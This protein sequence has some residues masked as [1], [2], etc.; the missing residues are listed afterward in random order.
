MY[1]LLAYAGFLMSHDTA[2]INIALKELADG[3]CVS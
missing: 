2:L 1:A 3:K